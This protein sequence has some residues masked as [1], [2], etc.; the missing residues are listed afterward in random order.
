MKKYF[1][2]NGKEQHGPYSLDELKEIGLTDKT[3]VWF[4]GISNWSEAQSIPELKEF[5][6]LTPPP[7]DK[8]KPNNQTFDK[9]KKVL[10]KDFVNEIERKI[11]NNT[12]KKIFKY[13]LII[14]AV[15]GLAFIINMMMPSQERKEKNNATEFLTIQKAKLRHIKYDFGESSRIDYWNVEGKLINNAKS[16]TYKDIKLEIE[17][18]TETNTSLGKKIVTIYQV[19]PPNNLQDEYERERSFQFKLDSDI[20]KNTNSENTIIK[21]IDAS[22]YEEQK[23]SQ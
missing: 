2:H 9:A 10:D 5:A 15:L 18:F 12:G 23:A 14:L 11:P 16:V 1:L 8:A 13:S 22:V 17:F 21:L 19:F 4:D 20:P 6:T 3:M 7:F